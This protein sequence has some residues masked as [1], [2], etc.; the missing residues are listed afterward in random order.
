MI[1]LVITD[2]DGV[3]TDGTVWVMPDGS[4]VCRYS[5]YDG[6]AIADMR[7]AG[8]EV[9]LVSR[10]AKAHRHRAEKLGVRLVHDDGANTRAT[11]VE[12][13][14]RDEGVGLSELCYVGDARSDVG[15]LVIVHRADGLAAY[16][17]G[18]PAWHAAGSAGY[19]PD[20]SPLRSFGTA[21]H[22]VMVHV[23]LRVGQR[24]AG[25]A[26]S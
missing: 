13:I 25:P 1:R 15:A 22:D 8:V 26:A 21:G 7:A 2:V 3:L 9:V 5:R 23:Q 18:S 17:E 19:A 6:Q 12:D 4:E 10:D 16:P 24:N 14:A 11:V 20:H